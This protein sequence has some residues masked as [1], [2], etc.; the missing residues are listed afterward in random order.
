[1]PVAPR[2]FT[3]SAAGRGGLSCAG[4]TLTLGLKPGCLGRDMPCRYVPG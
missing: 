2:H 4:V 1:M 3:S